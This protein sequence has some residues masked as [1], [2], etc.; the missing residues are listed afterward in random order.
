[1]KKNTLIF[2]AILV[3]VAI[4]VIVAI[5]WM[6][7]DIPIPTGKPSPIRQWVSP[8]GRL[9]LR[10]I[11]RPED[12][13]AFDGCGT[14][15]DLWP[16]IHRPRAHSL[17]EITLHKCAWDEPACIGDRVSL[18]MMVDGS[19]R[20]SMEKTPGSAWG[21][22]RICF[23]NAEAG[24]LDAFCSMEIRPQP[25]A[26]YINVAPI[27]KAAKWKRVMTEPAARKGE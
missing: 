15:I 22:L 13:P 9:S 21:P 25:G 7:V 8:D 23:D 19:Y 18:S 17:T 6:R 20:L 4:G 10:T 11:V 14:A 5:N 1:M 26:V 2:I 24:S 12:C 3:L 27:G 16:P